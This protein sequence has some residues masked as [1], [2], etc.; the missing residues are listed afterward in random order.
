[1]GTPVPLIVL[2]AEAGG[3][4]AFF[5][6]AVALVVSAAAIGYLFVRL[7]IVPITG[8]LLAGALIGPSV[9]GLVTEREAVDAIAEVGVILLLFTIGIE[10]SLERLARI[11]RLVLLGGGLQVAGAV[12]LTT[13]LLLPLGVALPAA[14]FTGF[15]VALSSTAIVLKLLADR[16]ETRTPT[17]QT[18]L[19]FLIFQDLAV[20]VMVLV[21]PQLGG[22]GGSPLELAWAFARAAAVIAVVL[23]VARRV[24]PRLLEGVARACSPEVFLLS[25]VAIC[26][27]TAFLTAMAGVSL[28]LGAFLAGLLVSESR[29]SSQALGEVL[30]LQIIFAAAF[31]L[32]V[33]TLLDVRFLLR[34]PLLI[35]GAVAL[36]LLVKIVTTGIGALVVGIGAATAG[37]T[38][39]L[40]AQVGEFSFVLERAGREVGLSPAG[41]GEAGAQAFIGATVLL[42]VATPG[43]GTL[44]NV[45]GR[46]L[47]TR[48]R[49]RPAPIRVAAANSPLDPRDHVLI[50]GWGNGA[51]HLAADLAGAGIPHVITTLNP[52]GAAQATEAGHEVLLGDS[53]KRHILEQAG[54]REARV[55]V[56]A[57]DEPEAAVRIAA[58]CRQLAP[59][60]VIVVRAAAASE[61]EEFVIAGAD[62][63]VSADRTSLQGLSKAV[64]RELIEPPPGRTFV[65]I[66]K[67]VRFAPDPDQACPHVG[68]IRAV[69]PSAHGCEQCLRTGDDWVHLRIC[70]TCGHVGCCD[71]SPNRHASAHARAGGHALICSAEPGEDWAYCYLDLSLLSPLSS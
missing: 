48:A 60:A 43:L 25:I 57:D 12:A 18:A 32:S 55:I 49:R 68:A 24:M 70:L 66:A 35:A 4:P 34:E 23:V 2:A 37:S 51:R 46:R 38:A 10:F 41:L 40:L 30:P 5:P 50:C 64:L 61:L 52:D 6:Q 19:A 65:D 63:V 45:L 7:R 53:T 58:L 47:D 69:L 59:Q 14:I 39:L 29:H 22:D 9:L 26:L 28:S 44:G 62:K 27:G 3:M 31:F 20:V 71:S 17:G 36:V 56:V 11:K 42:M 8:F 1:M 13:A 67:V 33:G 15:L 54:V 21:L 16:L